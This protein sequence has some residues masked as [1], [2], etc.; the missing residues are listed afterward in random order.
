MR[1]A[2]AEDLRRKLLKKDDTSDSPESKETSS[3][4]Q[5]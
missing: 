5:E 2:S 1:G 4:E 3:S